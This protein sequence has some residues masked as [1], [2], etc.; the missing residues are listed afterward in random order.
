M[1]TYLY[2][3]TEHGEFE[4]IQSMKDPQLDHCPECKKQGKP[5]VAP[6]KLIALSTF[7]LKGG[8][9]AADKYSK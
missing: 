6:K 7:Q 3:C 4:V 2:E 8:G 9:W 1:A 5:D